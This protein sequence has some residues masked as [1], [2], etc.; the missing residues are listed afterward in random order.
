MGLGINISERVKAQEEI[1]ETSEKLRQLT[2]HLQHIR[3]EERKRIGREIHDELGQQLTAI[4]M[5]VAWIDKQMPEET[6]NIKTKLKN[7]TT[8]LD[9]SN[10]SIRKILNELRIGVLDHHSLAEALQWQGQQFYQNTGIPIAFNFSKPFL[11]VKESI[12][13]CVFR[14]FQEALTNIIRYA[15]AKNVTTSLFFIDDQ[16]NFTISDDGDGFDT[17]LLKNSKTFGILGMKERV[18]SV[19][20]QFEILSSIQN[21]TQ[22]N[23]T[24]PYKP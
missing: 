14:V 6:T 15:N 2:A 20:G 22:I 17:A 23:I 24:I 1:K 4:K 13:T 16:I 5:D 3:E 7:I 19:D 18:S 9:A 21:G 8:L 10:S 11:Q 12:A